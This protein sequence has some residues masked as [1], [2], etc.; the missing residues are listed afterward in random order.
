M[1]IAS[2]SPL[3]PRQAL[4]AGEQFLHGSLFEAALFGDELL[5]G[6]DESIRIAQRLGDGF[7]FGFPWTRH[8]QRRKSIGPKI[9]QSM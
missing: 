6:V 9:E 7:L 3:E 2:H 4:L 8:L 5:K 1:P